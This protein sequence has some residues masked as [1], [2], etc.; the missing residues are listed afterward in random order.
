MLWERPCRDFALSLSSFLC[1]CRVC[2]SLSNEPTKTVQYNTLA[3]DL[4][5]LNG[6]T[7]VSANGLPFVHARLQSK[8]LLLPF[9]H[10]IT[11]RDKLGWVCIWSLTLPASHRLC[12]LWRRLTS[13]LLPIPSFFP[14]FL[15]SALLSPVVDPFSLLLLLLLLLLLQ[16]WLILLL[17]VQVIIVVASVFF[18][19]FFPFLPCRCSSLSVLS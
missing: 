7:P 15:F 12:A 9:T 14:S 4:F 3:F 13:L 19:V 6:Q 1:A 5:F 10:T 8:S 2:L 17:P 16:R 11:P 18:V